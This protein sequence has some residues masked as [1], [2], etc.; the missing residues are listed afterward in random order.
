MFNINV[1]T[2]PPLEVFPYL[3][4]KIAY[5]N[6]NW[7]AVYL[8]LCK[9]RRRWGI[10][11]SVIERTV[12]IVRSRVDMYKVVAQSVLLYGRKR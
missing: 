6:S 8:N 12:E 11:V 7:A 5:N 4:R 1:D 9:A 2:L 10:V 3:G